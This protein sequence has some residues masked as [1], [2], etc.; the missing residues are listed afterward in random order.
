MNEPRKKKL[1]DNDVTDSKKYLRQVN[2][3]NKDVEV[4]GRMAKDSHK[5]MKLKETDLEQL[6]IDI[7]LDH[8]VFEDQIFYLVKLKTQS[9]KYSVWL[10]AGKVTGHPSILYYHQVFMNSPEGLDERII[11]FFVHDIVTREPHDLLTL[12]KLCALVYGRTEEVV[13]ELGLTFEELRAKALRT[14]P[15]PAGRLHRKRLPLLRL[16]RFAEA[17]K[18]VLTANA[19]WERE[20]S[21]A[22]PVPVLVENDVDLEVAPT[23]YRFIRDYESSYVDLTARPVLSCTC[24]DCFAERASCCASHFGGRFAYDARGRLLLPPGH[25]VYECN[26]SCA[27]GGACPNRVVQRGP[28]RPLAVFRTRDGRGWGLRTLAP[29]ERG[30][31]VL[32]YLGE[33]ITPLDAEVRDAAYDVTGAT[34]LFDLS[35]GAFTVDAGQKGNASRFINH[36]CDPNLQVYTVWGDQQDPT[37]PRLAFFAR[38]RL[39]RGEEL[40]FDYQMEARLG[41]E[42]LQGDRMRCRCGAPS[43]REFLF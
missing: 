2:W 13:R 33:V 40:T 1:S 7:I 42:Y 28:T 31:F 22:S 27:C 39:P 8:K 4:G 19:E 3:I 21:D 29:L 9:L 12:T 24:E 14:L 30:Q 37:L 38:R 26:R 6:D 10:S 43:C 32:E 36:S 23:S 20:I 16:M 15:I 11:S 5:G 18:A 34:Y 35:G 41:D 25:E 17:R